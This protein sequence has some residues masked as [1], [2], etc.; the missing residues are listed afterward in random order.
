MEEPNILQVPHVPTIIAGGRDYRF[1]RD[2]VRRLDR[3]PISSV[4]SGGAKGADAEGERWATE[5]GIPL[6][7]VPA[8]WSQHGRSAGALRN[9]EMAKIAKAAV[10]FPGGRGSAHMLKTA[11]DYGLNVYDF[12]ALT[13]EH[14]EPDGNTK[15]DG[16]LWRSGT[17]V[18]MPHVRHWRDMFSETC[19]YT[20]DDQMRATHSIEDVTRHRGH[21]VKV[22]KLG[23][24]MRGHGIEH[25]PGHFSL[26]VRPTDRLVD[27]IEAY[28]I[29][30]Q[31]TTHW[32]VTEIRGG[33][34]NVS[35][36]YGQ[37]I[38]FKFVTQLSGKVAMEAMRYIKRVIHDGSRNGL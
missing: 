9:I 12:F 1:T 19:N 32:G 22:G 30:I 26:A 20:H 15:L 27:L 21:G 16:V 14:L 4:I 17:P 10:V 25:L 35:F 7:V 37:I 24:Y 5:R 38:G 23:A 36:S 33:C 34:L 18:L 29:S 13:H 6:L 8:D 31:D 11:H 28:T 3:L 2:D